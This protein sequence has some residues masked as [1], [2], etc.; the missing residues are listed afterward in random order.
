MSGGVYGGGKF[1]IYW[2]F[3]R[4]NKYLSYSAESEGYFV[5]VQ[6]IVGS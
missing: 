1:M 6:W 5:T 4:Y 2:N 3:F